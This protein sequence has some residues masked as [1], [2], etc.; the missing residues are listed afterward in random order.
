MHDVYRTVPSP[1]GDCYSLRSM[2]SPYVFSFCVSAAR[3]KTPLNWKE[4]NNTTLLRSVRSLCFFPSMCEQSLYVHYVPAP[5]LTCIAQVVRHVLSFVCR[6]RPSFH[7]Q[8]HPPFN[9]RSHVSHD[10][11]PTPPKTH[12]VPVP[13]SLL[14]PRWLHRLG[15]SLDHLAVQRR[16]VV[17]QGLRRLCKTDK[18][19]AYSAVHYAQDDGAD[20][21]P[22]H[23]AQAR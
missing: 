21:E 22:E 3:K 20:H 10:H 1:V 18:H 14:L 11:P 5:A 13:R 23:E 17:L 6:F 2:S 16:V 9:S 19:G 12:P 15:P 7:P 8:P 4:I